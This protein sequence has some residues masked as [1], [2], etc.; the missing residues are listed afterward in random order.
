MENRPLNLLKI[1]IVLKDFIWNVLTRCDFHFREYLVLTQI[2]VP[3]LALIR[4]Y[5]SIFQLI[6]TLFIRLLCNLSA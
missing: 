4:I 5:Y 2:F 1:A 3:I 6:E